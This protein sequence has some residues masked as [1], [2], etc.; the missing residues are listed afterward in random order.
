ME[1]YLLQNPGHN[2]VYFSASEQLALAELSIASA[3]FQAEVGDISIKELAGVRYLSFSS[4]KALE[5]TDL[6][7]LARLSFSWALF[8]HGNDSS[9]DPVLMPVEMQSRP[10]LDE[11]I[12][13]LMKYQGKTNEMFT[14]LMLNVA[15]HSAYTTETMSLLDPVA[16]KGTTLFEAAAK[17]LNAH[18]IEI[19]SKQTH[20]AEVYFKKFL[21]SERV[22]HHDQKR[23]IY[24]SGKNNA[25]YVH[26]FRFAQ[27]RADMKAR[28]RSRMVGFISGKAQEALR[29]FK[30]PQFHCIVGDLPY[31]IQH[32]SKKNEQLDGFTRNPEEL[33]MESLEGWKRV[34]FPEGVIV[35]AWNSFLLRKE[36]LAE[37]FT[38][39]GFQVLRDRPYDQ[40]EHMV[41]RT[42]KRDIIVARK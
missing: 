33:V 11:K 24:S 10:F 32:G 12:S 8:V 31:G 42:I 13:S 23:Q 4:S 37:L 21:E 20:E 17:G 6:S 2:W 28:E 22:I 35:L 18:G 25:V 5:A 41:D 40:F 27:S 3:N 36:K 14:R 29:Y 26:E 15:I 1:Y 16:G 34:L 38:R 30:G 19:D 7:L 39:S 9:G